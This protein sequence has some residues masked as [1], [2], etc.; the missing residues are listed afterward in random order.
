MATADYN[1]Q[2]YGLGIDVASSGNADAIWTTTTTAGT[3][4]ATISDEALLDNTK[5]SQMYNHFVM[6]EEEKKSK[7]R[8][9]VFM[10][11]NEERRYNEGDK[12]ADPIDE[13]RVKVHKWLNPN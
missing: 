1:H 12:F 8:K 10:A 6:G 2:V 9:V 4:S 11:L 5:F 13:L 7:P 3:S